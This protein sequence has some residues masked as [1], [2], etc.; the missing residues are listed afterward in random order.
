MA[1]KI[2]LGRAAKGYA[3]NRISEI[4]ENLEIDGRYL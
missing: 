1:N 2:K 3:D 4:S